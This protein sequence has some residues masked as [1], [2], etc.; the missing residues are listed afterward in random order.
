MTYT[1]IEQRILDMLQGV[2]ARE[3]KPYSGELSPDK[4]ADL[5]YRFPVVFV[6]VSEM[7][8]NT[9]NTLDERIY[10]VVIN[11]GDTDL[12]SGQASGAYAIMEAVRDRLHRQRLFE[13]FSPLEL[14]YEKVVGINSDGVALMESVYEFKGLVK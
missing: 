9:R 12:R 2:P 7:R 13:G 14:V 11:A 5:A 6:F 3:I 10:K 4:L 1:E 8:N